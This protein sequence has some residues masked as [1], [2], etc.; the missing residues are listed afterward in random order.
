MERTIE[1]NDLTDEEL[2]LV[3]GGGIGSFL[4]QLGQDIKDMLSTGHSGG[5]GDGRRNSGMAA[6]VS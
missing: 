2:S 4:T 6:G 1:L 5:G 3:R